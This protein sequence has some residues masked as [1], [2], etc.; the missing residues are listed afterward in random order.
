MPGTESE[1]AVRIPLC[2]P[3][4]VSTPQAVISAVTE[5]IS[6]I[7]IMFIAASALERDIPVHFPV[8][9]PAETVGIPH[10]VVVSYSGRVAR[11]TQLGQKWQ[12]AIVVDEYYFTQ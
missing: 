12:V 1:Q 3:I 11:C 10:D 7:E 9:L 2:A 6:A 5:T 8:K 4:R